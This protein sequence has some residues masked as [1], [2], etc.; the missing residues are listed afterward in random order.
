MLARHP[1]PR[2]RR[3]G[4]LPRR[5]RP[6]PGSTRARRGVPHRE[7]PGG[8]AL[9]NRGARR[10]PPALFPWRRQPECLPARVGGAAGGPIGVAVRAVQ[11][12]R[13]SGRHCRY[14]KWCALLR[15]GGGGRA[16]SRADTPLPPR[17]MVGRGAGAIPVGLADR[18]QDLAVAAPEEHVGDGIPA[19]GGG[20]R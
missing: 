19:L 20:I 15:L 12:L 11:G 14:P 18:I 9:R 5:G 7:V 10:A 2:R 17:T 16:D 6:L 13:P 3:V 1:P 4:T 8:E